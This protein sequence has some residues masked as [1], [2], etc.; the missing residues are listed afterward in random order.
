M[1]KTNRLLA[2]IGLLAGISLVASAQGQLVDHFAGTPAPGTGKD[3][4]SGS[5]PRTKSSTPTYR[6]PVTTHIQRSRQSWQEMTSGS[7]P[8]TQ[9]AAPQYRNPVTTHVERSTK[10]WQEI[11]RE[12]PRTSPT[13][14]TLNY[15]ITTMPRGDS[16]YKSQ[17]KEV[18]GGLS[19]PR[20]SGEST[21]FGV[22]SIG[23]RLNAQDVARPYL[24][25]PPLVMPSSTSGGTERVHSPSYRNW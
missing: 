3:M 15:K 11:L 5:R 13:P 16:A 23:P 14:P 7:R 6:D 17:V 19:S 24:T 22:Q 12:I 8:R 25:S 2:V 4:F 18:F 21:P 10:T 9:T 1:M 20:S